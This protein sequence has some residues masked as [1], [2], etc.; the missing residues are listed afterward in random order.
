MTT[1]TATPTVQQGT[2]EHID[3]TEIVV[4]ANVRSEAKLAL[5]R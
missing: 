3:P 1:N 4:E 2:V 5:L